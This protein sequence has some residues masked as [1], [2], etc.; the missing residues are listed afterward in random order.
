MIILLM[1]WITGFHYLTQSRD[2]ELH[3]FFRRLYYLPI[4][5]GAFKFRLKGGLIFSVLAV[6]IYSPHLI[7]YFG[8]V[9][10]GVIN[11]F[12]EALMFV[13]VGLITGYLVE[14][15]YQARKSL[16]QQIVKV[17]NLEN[18]THNV[19]DSIDSG[20]IAFDYRGDFKSINRRAEV[21]FSNKEE[22][23]QFIGEK[24][25]LNDINRVIQQ[26][27]K[28]VEKEIDYCTNEDQGLHLK[29]T[30]FPIEN[31]SRVIEGAV[32]VVQDVT[33]VKRL[34]G[35]VRRGE[36][37]AAVGELASGIAH[38]IRNPLGIIK[39]ISQTINKEVEDEE[40]KEGLEI[41]EHEIERANKVVQGLL[42]F[43]KPNKV[44]IEKINLN[45]LLD[46]LVMITRK[47]AEQQDVAIELSNMNDAYEIEGDSDKLKQALI[48]II[49]NGIQA[50]EQ[51]GRLEISLKKTEKEESVITFKDEGRGIEKRIVDQI[52]NPFFTT[53]EKGTGLG[54]SITHRIIEEHQGSIEVTSEIN[55]GTEIGIRLPLLNQEGNFNE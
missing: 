51:G 26:K 15:D 54:L 12:L 38:E 7:I 14:A 13:I 55:R 17:V 37:L 20:V 44:K 1:I 8:E 43:S 34:E 27:I 18:Y 2:W 29:A 25:L 32:L 24:N 22:V 10:I 47:F 30:I 33:M 46:E 23:N 48:N 35:Q 6:L 9:N 36:R 53:K 21:I 49:L 3:D 28:F 52:F 41:I 16:E 4:I 50:M 40:I 45:R 19:L 39:T 31:I 42:D 11:Q 5:I